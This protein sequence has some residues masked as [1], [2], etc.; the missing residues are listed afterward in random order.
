M[1]TRRWQYRIN[2]HVRKKNCPVFKQS[3]QKRRTKK[4]TRKNGLVTSNHSDRV[5]SIY[6]FSIRNDSFCVENIFKVQIGYSACA[7]SI[8]THINYTV[9]SHFVANTKQFFH[10]GWHKYRTGSYFRS[11]IDYRF[12]LFILATKWHDVVLTYAILSRF[13]FSLRYIFSINNLA[14]RMRMHRLLLRDWVYISMLRPSGH[15]RNNSINWNMIW[16]DSVK[17]FCCSVL[18]SNGRRSFIRASSS[19]RFP[20]CFWFCGGWTCHCWLW[21]RSLV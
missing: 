7:N 12:F 20:S 2:W 21:Y 11:E 13:A 9:F 18:Y 5:N 3:K 4:K 1:C 15:R 10:N 14:S 6:R 17:S 16:K 19:E 8:K